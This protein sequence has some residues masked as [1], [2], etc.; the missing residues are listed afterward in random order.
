MGSAYDKEI[1]GQR[2]RI[3]VEQ[4]PRNCE[5]LPNNTIRIL[6]MDKSGTGKEY[7]Y[8]PDTQWNRSIANTAAT[9]AIE[10]MYAEREFIEKLVEVGEGKKTME[11][12]RKE[13]LAKYT[14][15]TK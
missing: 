13:I 7:M 9:M 6:I 2:E 14:Q 15:K 8:I 5:I 3:L 10:N 4:E 12:L 1:R 11:Q